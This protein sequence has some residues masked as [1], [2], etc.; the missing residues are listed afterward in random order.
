MSLTAKFVATAKTRKPGKPDR[1]LDADGLYLNVSPETGRK[2]WVLRFSLKGRVT[3]RS[4]GSV[5][6]VTLAQARDEA[7]RLRKLIRTGRPIDAKVVTFKEVADELLAMKIKGWR[8]AT[9]EYQ[10]RLCVNTY[11]KAL[12]DENV[13]A[14]TVARTS[15]AVAGLSDRRADGSEA[16]LARC[17]ATT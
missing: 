17:Y 3:E 2:T 14:I 12:L 9:S 8:S 15:S 6:F 7:F 5:E 4:L 13:G 1:F 11:A 10:F 16:P